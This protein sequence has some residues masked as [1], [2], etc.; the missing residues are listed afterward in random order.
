MFVR[1]AIDNGVDIE[2]LDDEVDPGRGKGRTGLQEAA[3]RGHVEVVEMI[4]D[5]N[6][7]I[8][9]QDYWNGRTALMEAA[10]GGHAEVVMMLI[11]SGASTEI[12]DYDGL[13]AYDWAE[14]YN[15][16]A[17]IEKQIKIWKKM[18]KNTSDAAS[19]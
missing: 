17:D 5:Q 4:L 12:R 10:K 18:S 14:Q 15:R 2:Q 13:T 11:N 3:A 7:R 6:P 1:A 9:H 19:V 16:K 8:D